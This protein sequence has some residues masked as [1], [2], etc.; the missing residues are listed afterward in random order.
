MLFDAKSELP[1]DPDLDE[2]IANFFAYQKDSAPLMH[3]TVPMVEFIGRDP[4]LYDQ[5]FNFQQIEEFGKWLG[6]RTSTELTI[7][8]LQTGGPKLEVSL[9]TDAQ[10]EFLTNYYSEDYE[11]YGDYLEKL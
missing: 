5:I 4:G 6:A 8:K 11:I 1:A 3:H 7:P 10:K 9:L 2:F